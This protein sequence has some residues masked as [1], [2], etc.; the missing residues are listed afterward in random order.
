MREC[1]L[2]ITKT[3]MICR[4]LQRV[5]PLVCVF[6]LRQTNKP[7]IPNTYFH[8]LHVNVLIKS[9]SEMILRWRPQSFIHVSS[10]SHELSNCLNEQIDRRQLILCVCGRL[11]D[12]CIDRG[13]WCSPHSVC[14][15]IQAQGH[16]NR[17]FEL[18]V[19]LSPANGIK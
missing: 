4:I 14:C 8:A 1:F 11:C 6:V 12:Y 3:E 19:Q 10:Q 15:I 16:T 7:T 9:E 2:F 5:T 13:T 17:S 18:N